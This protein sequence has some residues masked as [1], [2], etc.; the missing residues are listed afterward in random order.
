[1]AVI[2]RTT[3]LALSQTQQLPREVTHSISRPAFPTRYHSILSGTLVIFKA[4]VM[5]KLL[6]LR[7]AGHLPVALVTA[8]Q[9]ILAM[10]PEMRRTLMPESTKGRKRDL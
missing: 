2:K 5:V 6:R 8:R 9:V 1:M 7:E 10:R 3:V 4:R